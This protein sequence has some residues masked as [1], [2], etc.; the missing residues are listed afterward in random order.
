M[1]I[2][3]VELKNTKN[4]CHKYYHIEL[5]QSGTSYTVRTQWGRIG[6]QPR[7]TDKG[8]FP[9]FEKANGVFQDIVLNKILKGYEQTPDDDAPPPAA[10]A[11]PVRI[12][13]WNKKTI[14][15][16]P[17]AFTKALRIALKGA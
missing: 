5:H 6:R 15:A 2:K 3:K 17:A 16:N 14:D 9:D 10:P 12:T 8:T 7:E 11:M 4:G 13:V 1:L